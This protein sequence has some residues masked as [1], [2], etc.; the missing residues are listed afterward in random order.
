MTALV[1]LRVSTTLSAMT[2][3]LTKE[4]VAPASA[5]SDVTVAKKV[6]VIQFFLEIAIVTVPFLMV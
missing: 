6:L 3:L 4:R 2:A 1:L 5:F